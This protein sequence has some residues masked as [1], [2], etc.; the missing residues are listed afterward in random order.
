[1]PSPR[2]SSVTLGDAA[3]ASVS[4][5]RVCSSSGSHGAHGCRCTR[6]G[7]AG[8]GRGTVGADTMPLLLLGSLDSGAGALPPPPASALTATGGDASATSGCV[9]APTSPPVPA[10]VAPTGRWRRERV[11]A[12]P[13]RAL[14]IP[15]GRLPD[16]PLLPLSSSDSALPLPLSRRP[17]PRSL[18]RPTNALPPVPDRT[19][20][21]EAVDTAVGR[22]SSAVAPSARTARGSSRG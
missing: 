20:L 3:M 9:P 15:R 22:E 17:W 6:G 2:R 11:T 18:V 19:R 5:P 7:G 16:R 10:V 14:S 12:M 13:A 1:M 21:S 8:R 4:A